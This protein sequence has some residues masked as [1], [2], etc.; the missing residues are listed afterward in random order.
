MPHT[1]TPHADLPIMLVALSADFS[2]GVE[3]AMLNDTLNQMLDSAGR[4]HYVIFDWRSASLSMN[5]LMHGAHTA[6]NDPTNA[7]RNPHI[8][9]IGFVGERELWQMM[10]DNLNEM[11]GDDLAPFM[12]FATLDAALEFYT[13]QLQA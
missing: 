4:D 1:I 3:E 2:L 7:M 10:V 13:E 8:I 11:A 6:L 5:D 9:G 12:A